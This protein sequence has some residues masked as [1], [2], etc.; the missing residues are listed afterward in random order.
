MRST[1]II[2][3]RQVLYMPNAMTSSEM[4]FTRTAKNEGLVSN[5]MINPLPLKYCNMT[6]N[7]ER[8]F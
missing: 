1:I 8:R 3:R 4:F 5:L 7:E 2:I 6:H